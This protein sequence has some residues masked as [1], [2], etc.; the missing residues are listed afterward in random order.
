MRKNNFYNSTI[1]RNDFVLSLQNSAS[2]HFARVYVESCDLRAANECD[3]VVF[4]AILVQISFNNSA[5]DRK[6]S[7]FSLEL[8]KL[9]MS[10]RPQKFPSVSTIEQFE[11]F[12]LYF[13]SPGDPPRH[14]SA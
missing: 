7:S 10:V 13:A 14:I 1:N 3:C 5:E 4:R 9:F 2:E 6:L 8:R 12:S 11:T